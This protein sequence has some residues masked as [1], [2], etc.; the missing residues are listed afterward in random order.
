MGLV[1]RMPVFF[2]KILR[3]NFSEIWENFLMT[4]RRG[5][6]RIFPTGGLNVSCREMAARIPTVA[7]GVSLRERRKTVH[8]R[9][10]SVGDE[11]TS[12]RTRRYTRAFPCRRRREA[13]ARPAFHPLGRS[14]V[15]HRSRIAPHVSRG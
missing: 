9:T 14:R 11:R 5:T 1:C 2:R 3:L 4:R 7:H 8:R 12:R 15:T 13:S 10:R 6:L